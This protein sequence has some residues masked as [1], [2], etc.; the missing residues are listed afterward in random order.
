MRE[1]TIDPPPA[2]LAKNCVAWSLTGESELIGDG[3]IELNWEKKIEKLDI[4][5]SVE[6][7]MPLSE[8]P[9]SRPRLGTDRAGEVGNDRR[10]RV[11]RAEVACGRSIRSTI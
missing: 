3:R 8:A 2:D 1:K 7:P 10:S 4:G 6:L 5:K 11:G 9:G